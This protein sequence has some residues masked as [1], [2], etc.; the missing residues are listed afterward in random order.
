DRTD[1]L[2]VDW[3]SDSLSGRLA[4]PA[5][6]TWCTGRGRL[7]VSA[8]AGDSGFAVMVLPADS[9]AAAPVPGSYP[10]AD[11]GA[12]RILRP[13]AALALRRQEESR[14]AGYQSRSGSLDLTTSEGGGWRAEFDGRIVSISGN[15]TLAV[16]GEFRLAADPVAGACDDTVNAGAPPDTL[17]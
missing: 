15:E 5:A 3:E 1:R 14:G 13:L 11:P 12:G 6:A 10:V 17:P 2:E 9:L 7:L 8:S 16:R 4:G